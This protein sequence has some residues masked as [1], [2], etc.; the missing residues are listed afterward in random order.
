VSQAEIS[1]EFEF[2]AAHWL[3]DNA[4]LKEMLTKIF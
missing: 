2:D 4:T 1:K 3:L